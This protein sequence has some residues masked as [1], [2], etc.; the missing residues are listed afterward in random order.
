[1]DERVFMNLGLLK[2][3]AVLEHKRYSV[4]V[5]DLS[6][7]KNFE[8]VAYEHAQ[9][10]DAAV[11]GITSTTP[12]L[13]ACVKVR[14]ALYSAR[15]DARTI[16]GGPHITLVNAAL[17]RERK[18]GFVARAH[19]HF[20]Q[21]SDLF[22]VLVAGDGET[23]IEEALTTKEKLIDVDDAKSKGFMSDEDF[24]NSPWPARHLVD[25]GSYHYQIDGERSLSLIAQLGC[26]FA[27]GFCA[28]RTSPMLRR[29]RLRSTANVVAEVQHIYETY[30]VKAFTLYDDELN[31]NPSMI[32]LMNGLAD[33]QAKLGVAF[34]FRG[35]IKAQLFTKAQAEAMKRAGFSYILV[36]FESGSPRILEN[37]NKKATRD[38][39]TRCVEFAK[40]HGL[41]TK[42]FMSIGHPGESHETIQATLDWILRAELEEFNCTIITSTPGT[43]YYDHAVQVLPDKNVWTYVCPSGD[44]LHSIDL[45]YTVVADYYNG[46]PHSYQSFV[47]TDYIK[48]EELVLARDH[49]E[50]TARIKLRLPFNQRAASLCYDQSMGQQGGLPGFILRQTNSAPASL[51]GS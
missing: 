33:L 27:C 38:E 51:Q 8:Q 5:L 37:I 45:D 49:L 46:I 48:S 2:V 13:P 10:T 23:T 34:K 19:R 36:G 3:A 43:F 21:A 39:N 18:L 9:A 50:E 22:T 12:Q 32:E 14:H 24:E 29:I 28:G 20:Q 15:P 16:L 4:E 6:G 11:F 7:I 1:M 26:P 31:V 25:V 44:R 30:N 42:G 47:F 40:K 41:K 35:C 17:K